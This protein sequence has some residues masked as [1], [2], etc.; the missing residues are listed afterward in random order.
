MGGHLAQ[1]ATCDAGVTWGLGEDSTPWVHTGGWGGGGLLVGSQQGIGP[2]SDSQVF[3]VYE[4]QRW[5]PISGYSAR[6][7]PT[8][9]PSWSDA[10]GEQRRSKEASVL[11]GPWQWEGEWQAD[12][13]QYA[14]DFPCSFHP[15]NK[16][17]DTVR[18]RRWHRVARYTSTGPWQE[19]GNTRLRALSLHTDAGGDIHVWG[20]TLGGDVLYRRG[21]AGESPGGQAWEHVAH[22]QPLCS[23][24][25]CRSQVWGVGENGCAYWRDGITGS[26][27]TGEHWQRVDPPRRTTLVE[28]GVGEVG[29]W[30]RDSEQGVWVREGSQWQGVGEQRMRRLCVGEGEVWG[31]T[32]EGCLSKR[33]GVSREHPKGFSWVFSLPGDWS[34]L[35]LN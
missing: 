21:V 31:V 14:L 15:G 4:N 5:N 25:G 22:D 1:V 13:W 34:H 20:V 32:L 7:L 17:T 23:I 29:V 19:L 9:R 24:S 16:M 12:D 26:Q 10:S 6:G 8:D 18:R 11:V 28:V 35:S 33:L 27:P 2:V 30:A 3:E